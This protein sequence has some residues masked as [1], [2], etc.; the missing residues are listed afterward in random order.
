MTPL[1]PFLSV[2]LLLAAA[3]VPAAEPIVI[4]EIDSRT[5]QFAAQG[6]ALHQGVTLAIEEANTRG[7]IAGR[8]L[9]LLSRD[10]EGKPERAVAAAEEL[11]GRHG[12]VALVGGYV[13]SLVGPVALLPPPLMSGSPRAATGTSSASRASERTS[14]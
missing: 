1:P 5:G 10:D 3:P 12:A 8:P 11:T 9:A 7:G 4:G 14:T 13:D 2:L 6:S